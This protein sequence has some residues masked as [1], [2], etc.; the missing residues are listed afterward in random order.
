M[1]ASPSPDP[2]AS[3]TA[4]AACGGQLAF[5][6]ARQ[7]LVCSVCRTEVTI[8]AVASAAVD[9]AYDL[10][11]TPDDTWRTCTEI[12]P[13]VLTQQDARAAARAWLVQEDVPEGSIQDAP[14]AVMV[15]FFVFRLGG[16][17]EWQGRR[18]Q[19]R[20]RTH[21]MR[22]LYGPSGYALEQTGTEVRWTQVAGSVR[23]PET[24]IAL[25]ACAELPAAVAAIAEWRLA[26]LRPFHPAWHA[27][28][29]AL[30]P[31]RA[32]D[33][34][35]ADATAV[36]HSRLEQLA[37]EAMGGDAQEIEAL[38]P[39]LT[40]ATFR[41]VLLPVYTG[42]FRH[43]GKPFPYAVN[44]QTGQVG[45][46]TPT[47][48]VRRFQDWL[49]GAAVV[50]VL[51][52]GYAGWMLLNGYEPEDILGV[53]LMLGSM[54]LVCLGF[55]WLQDRVPWLV[56]LLVYGAG[57]WGVSAGLWWVTESS[58]L[59]TATASLLAV[60]GALLLFAAWGSRKPAEPSP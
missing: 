24:D 6:P 40:P 14:E 25:P 7:C 21:V 47:T 23:L 2:A 3:A 45:G 37:R 11:R 29:P 15:P 36:A 39:E 8:P 9:L 51:A 28:V 19:R 12:L 17:A 44:G 20:H 41:L 33:A 30:V 32:L 16:T 10:H 4:C 43:D 1:T 48:V 58:G 54:V 55:L 34:A 59:V 60:M 38:T 53:P 49:T 42:T 31:G 26:H 57:S 56:L 52:L 50:L 27:G 18:G 22:G 5:A 46:T 13:L 35:F